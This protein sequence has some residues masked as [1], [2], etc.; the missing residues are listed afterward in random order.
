MTDELKKE[1]RKKFNYRDVFDTYVTVTDMTDDELGFK[2]EPYKPSH[3]GDEIDP[4][5]YTLVNDL[6][7]L[8]MN[9]VKYISRWRDKDGLKDLYKAKETIERLIKY[10]ENQ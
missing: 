7:G 10:W 3:Y 8:E 1:H 6:G 5:T 9:V 2:N 4:Y